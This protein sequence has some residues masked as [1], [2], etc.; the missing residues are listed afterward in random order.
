MKRKEGVKVDQIKELQEQIEALKKTVSDLQN[1]TVRVVSVKDFISQKE[2]EIFY[3]YFISSGEISNMP[4]IDVV[5][6]RH[7]HNK[8]SLRHYIRDLVRLVFKS[9]YGD[10]SINILKLLADEKQRESYLALY[11]NYC[12]IVLGTMTNDYL[13]KK[14]GE[15]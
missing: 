10:T 14:E 9:N 4:H 5:T 3:K 13:K 2:C 8:D 7:H 11:E 6:A 1:G 12:K 15:S